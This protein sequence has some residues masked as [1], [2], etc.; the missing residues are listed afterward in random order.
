MSR[1]QGTQRAGHS[2]VIGRMGVTSGIAAGAGV[3]V[4]VA[5]GIPVSITPG[6]PVAAPISIPATIAMAVA[7]PGAAD[8]EEV[9]AV[10]VGRNNQASHD[11]YRSDS[12]QGL[13]KHVEHSIRMPAF[14][15]GR[16]TNE[17][18][19][20]F[21]IKLTLERLYDPRHGRRFVNFSE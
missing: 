13:C 12:Y 5:P 3:P 16:T 1:I 2:A 17:P 4:S 7:G 20:V 15:V 10:E 8:R 11:R 6:V 19:R 9:C 21:V 14:C 18:V